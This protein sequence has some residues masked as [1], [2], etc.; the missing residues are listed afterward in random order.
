MGRP[1]APSMPT[2]RQ[3]IEAH[4]AVTAIHPKARIKSVGPDGVQ[5][6]YPDKTAPASEWDDRPFS[7]DGA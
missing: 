4:K 3:V 6:D 2:E 1:S 5:F 7:G